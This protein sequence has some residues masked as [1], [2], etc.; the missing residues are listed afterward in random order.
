[1]QKTA[2]TS[3]A[4]LA[5]ALGLLLVGNA[6][7]PAQN[8]TSEAEPIIIA[9]FF[10]EA[11]DEPSSTKAIKLA[12]EDLNA[13]GVISRPV[14][15]LPRYFNDN[16]DRTQLAQETFDSFAVAGA[17]STSSSTALKIT[18]LTN[19]E[20]YANIVQCSG[21]ST[22]TKINNPS[23]PDSEDGIGADRNDT[24]FRAITNDIKQAKLV[25]DM[26]ADKEHTGMI[27]L[28][29][30]YGESFHGEIE[31][32]AQADVGGL[33]YAVPYPEGGSQVDF[34]PIIDEVLAKNAAGELNTII[35]VGDTVF[36]AFL[37]G[38]IEAPEPFVG[39]FIVTDGV[40]DDGVFLSQTSAF[41]Q[42]LARPGNRLLGTTPSGFSG[43]NSEQWIERYKQAKGSEGIDNFV[44]TFADCAYS[45]ALS[46]I[47]AEVKG[48]DPYA[49]LKVGLSSQ[50]EASLA[51]AEVVLVDPNP[52]G[53]QAAKEAL[54][55]GKKVQLNGASGE[56][57]YDQ[58]GDRIQQFYAIME[59]EGA[60]P[61]KWAASQVWD[62][63]EGVC[64]EGCE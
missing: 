17:I 18:R 19:L 63:V 11:P 46:L 23:T 39:T 54:Q 44:T 45:M 48:E 37:K 29:A 35:Y 47:E 42:W 34:Q 1:M 41:T 8:T 28:G 4:S 20:Q 31:A 25:W 2:F 27:Y 36:G 57:V 60:G 62:P 21:S 9:G 26:S 50:K 14:Q 56:L 55:A 3:F 53:L 61:Y 5:S 15:V 13:A 16:I 40:I 43:P 32:K 38:L 58:D 10:G 52:A 59:V 7:Q 33:A 51:G 6:C 30:P 49:Y 22:N 24:L 12:F 64:V